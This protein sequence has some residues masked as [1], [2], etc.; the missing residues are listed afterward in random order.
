[1][2]LALYRKFA[3]AWKY[4]SLGANSFVEPALCVELASRG[5][6]VVI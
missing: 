2:T 1:M 6:P 3:P 5:M 4:S